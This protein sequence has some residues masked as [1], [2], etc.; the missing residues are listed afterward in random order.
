MT[1]KEIKNILQELIDK[2]EMAR[3]KPVGLNFYNLLD[4]L[5]KLVKEL[6]L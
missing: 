4:E 6:D 1:D 2:Y 3:S 5:R